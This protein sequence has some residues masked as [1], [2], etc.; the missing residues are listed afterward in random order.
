MHAGGAI[1]HRWE[2]E[3]VAG[4][5]RAVLPVV[6]SLAFT[7]DVVAAHVY[8]RARGDEH[9]GHNMQAS[10]SCPSQQHGLTTAASLPWR[11]HMVSL[12]LRATPHFHPRLDC[13][14]FPTTQHPC[15]GAVPPG[16]VLQWAAVVST[17]LWGCL[18]PCLWQVRCQMTRAESVAS[19]VG[20][21][22]RAVNGAVHIPRSLLRLRE[23]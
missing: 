14:W 6:V 21:C 2:G 10:P 15:M 4:A 12:G 20:L 18:C 23:S 7:A 16:R 1:W 3:G 11:C 8:R 19:C 22:V 13:Q 17:C 9:M 5:V